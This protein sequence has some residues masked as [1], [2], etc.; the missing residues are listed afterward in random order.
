MSTLYPYE[1]Y[2]LIVS[3]LILQTFKDISVSYPGKNEIK[4]N[5]EKGVSVIQV[6]NGIRENM[7]NAGNI[8]CDDVLLLTEWD[9]HR[10]IEQLIIDYRLIM[11]REYELN[12]VRQLVAPEL[13]TRMENWKEQKYSDSA[14]EFEVI[15]ETVNI[16]GAEI[17]CKASITAISLY[18][19]AFILGQRHANDSFMVV[20]IK[21]VKNQ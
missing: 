12:R 8:T 7:I 10:I 18:D 3:E 14:K 11:N 16:T 19:A 5:Y 17:M 4:S 6:V 21:E 1:V 9:E 2:S 15:F 20:E 13:L